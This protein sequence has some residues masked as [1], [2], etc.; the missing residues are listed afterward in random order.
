MDSKIEDLIL[1]DNNN[2][3]KTNIHIV[4][5]TYTDNILINGITIDL[6]EK[7]NTIN[8]FKPN[9]LIQLHDINLKGTLRNDTYPPLNNYDKDYDD[10]L[11]KP[12][13]RTNIL[14]DTE[15]NALNLD[16]FS[17]DSE[18][19]YQIEYYNI[20][21]DKNLYASFNKVGIPYLEKSDFNKFNINNNTSLYYNLKNGEVNNKK[22]IPYSKENG[23]QYT[24]EDI[25]KLFFIRIIVDSNI[26]GLY[27]DY[28]NYFNKVEYR[29]PHI[30]IGFE[31]SVKN[32]LVLRRTVTADF[33]KGNLSPILTSDILVLDNAI[34]K[35]EITL[36]NNDSLNETR[37]KI[38]YYEDRIFGNPDKRTNVKP[39]ANLTP[40]AIVDQIYSG[41]D[42]SKSM[43]DLIDMNMN[44][45]FNNGVQYRYDFHV[46]IQVNGITAN[47]TT[48]NYLSLLNVIRYDTNART[49]EFTLYIPYNNIYEQGLL[50]PSPIIR[51]IE[52][53]YKNKYKGGMNNIVDYV[54]KYQK[55]YAKSSKYNL[56]PLIRLKDDRYDYIT[57]KYN[58]NNKNIDDENE[59]VQIFSIMFLLSK[60]SEIY[61][62]INYEKK[63]IERLEFR[64][65]IKNFIGDRTKCGGFYNKKKTNRNDTLNKYSALWRIDDYD[66]GMFVINKKDIDKYTNLT[67]IAKGYKDIDAI[68][69]YDTTLV[70]KDTI[71]DRL[72]NN[73]EHHIHELS[74]LIHKKEMTRGIKTE[75]ISITCDNLKRGIHYNKIGYV[76]ELGK[77]QTNSYFNQPVD[78]K[79]INNHNS[80]KRAKAIGYIDIDKIK[81]EFRR[82]VTSIEKLAARDF[83]VDTVTV[84]NLDM[85]VYTP[86]KNITLKDNLEFI[87]KYEDQSSTSKKFLEIDDSNLFNEIKKY[88]SQT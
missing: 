14:S 61:P 31:F 65:F 47:N 8:L 16:D 83:Y 70:L 18:N 69:K 15:V 32:E 41:A 26:K 71:T 62:C 88:L 12:Y 42:F 63:N 85:T 45:R 84:N 39:T 75:H 37:K 72:L 29:I 60:S 79:S 82:H 44:G 51:L 33:F 54:T 13:V 64:G 58:L 34:Y 40:N 68:T 67:N 50:I 3:K 1:N 27:F 53:L 25:K 21:S 81:L 4:N 66:N 77:I 30:I 35:N 10:F 38:K 59:L 9:S 73:I 11:L 48:Y 74:Q 5:K 80:Y 23:S 19:A 52:K 87:L 6:N 86:R 20:I 46:S 28:I 57:K 36:K 22:L 7:I 56:Y 78:V 17:L 43:K 2:Y 49:I 24:I 55:K 76:K